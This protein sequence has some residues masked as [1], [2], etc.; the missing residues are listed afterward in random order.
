MNIYV[1]GPMTTDKE[2]KFHGSAEITLL[3][4]MRAKAIG[5]KLAK[6]GYVPY[7]P[8]T[9]IGGWESEL[10]YEN[11]MRIH[12][13]FIRKWADALF[14]VGPSRGAD[15]EKEEAKKCGIPIFTSI[16]ELTE[17][18]F[19]QQLSPCKSNGQQLLLLQ[20]QL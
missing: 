17:A 15:I 16:K 11:I 9:H 13:T 6:I 3:N 4:V 14:F 19:I 1:S 8:H 10:D 7:V 2:G 20:Q 12:L 5:M 18:S